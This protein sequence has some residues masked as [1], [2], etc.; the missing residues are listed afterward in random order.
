MLEVPKQR[1]D[2]H[3]PGALLDGG[4]L[5]LELARQPLVVT[6]LKRKIAP[7]CVLQTGIPRGR[8][9]PAL[10]A[11]NATSPRVV[12][13][14]DRRGHILFGTIVDDDQLQVTMGLVQY[15]TSG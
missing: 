12:Q 8:R 13:S 14:G 10:L 2:R 3:R 9:P 11:P 1:A 6:V 15:A 5:K 7:G 4:H